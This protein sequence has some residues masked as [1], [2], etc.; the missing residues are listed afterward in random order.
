M[1]A[2]LT[3]HRKESPPAGTRIASC[4]IPPPF[5][6]G[7]AVNEDLRMI[8]RAVGTHESY[9]RQ[10][11][12]LAQRLEAR[13]GFEFIQHWIIGDQHI[14]Q[15]LRNPNRATTSRRAWA[16]RRLV[17]CIARSSD[18]NWSYHAPSKKRRKGRHVIAGYD[19]APHVRKR[20]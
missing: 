17:V 7:S 5:F 15:L 4:V 9:S 16:L 18:L 11:Q 20:C 12:F 13:I 1:C 14:F 8:L 2:T 10:P 3:R 6:Q 19:N